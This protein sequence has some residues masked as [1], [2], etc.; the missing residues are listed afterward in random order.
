MLTRI[1]DE[2]LAGFFDGEGTFYI[3]KQKKNGFEYPHATIMLSQSGEKG[4]QL[5]SAIQEIYGGAVYIHL[6]PGEHKATK[7][8]Y[9]LYWNKEE[10]VELIKKLLPYLNIKHDSAKEVLEYLTRKDKK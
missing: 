6:K 1:T 7:Y 5:L 4:L 3:G 2:Y 10:G 8:A 9:K